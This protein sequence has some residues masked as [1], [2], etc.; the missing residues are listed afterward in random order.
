MSSPDWNCPDWRNCV[1]GALLTKRWAVARPGSPHCVRP[2]GQPVA[3]FQSADLLDPRNRVHKFDCRRL[4][5]AGRIGRR[6]RIARNWLEHVTWAARHRRR[7]I[8]AIG[9]IKSLRSLDIDDGKY[10]AAGLERLSGLDNLAHLGL[11][12]RTGANATELASLAKLK[13]L[14]SLNVSD[15][16]CDTAGFKTLASLTQLED[17]DL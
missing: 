1:C 14:R 4:S 6:H 10:T 3:E 9:E 8:G 5:P 15:V 12:V 11:W 7:R 2:R 17:L 16:R 13:S